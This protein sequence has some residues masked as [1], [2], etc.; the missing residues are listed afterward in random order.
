MYDL[1]KLFANGGGKKLQK[2]KNWSTSAKRWLWWCISCLQEPASGQFCKKTTQN[3]H[4]HPQPA[5]HSVL[6]WCKQ[7]Q[8]QCVSVN[9]APCHTWTGL[10]QSKSLQTDVRQI[11]PPKL[12]S[13]A[14]FF[15]LLL[16]SHSDL[17]SVWPSA[18]IPP[19]L[20]P[21]HNSPTKKIAT[22]NM[23]KALSVWAA[24]FGRRQTRSVLGCWERSY[25]DC[26]VGCY[27]L[28]QRGG[29]SE[30]QREKNETIIN[31]QLHL[32]ESRERLRN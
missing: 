11:Q 9:A 7:S 24:T 26:P 31:N 28:G 16:L 18:S 4:T 10:I 20:S 12:F 29:K 25:V 2:G 22:V 1:R 14:Q 23:H 13:N 3:L 19:S 17:T 15:S 27:L 6:E 21:S 32:L 30:T 8:R 5:L